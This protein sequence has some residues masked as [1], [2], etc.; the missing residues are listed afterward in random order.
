[1]KKQTCY[2][3]VYAGGFILVRRSELGGVIGRGLLANGSG[4]TVG[5]ADVHE[6]RERLEAASVQPLCYFSADLPK[7]AEDHGWNYDPTDAVTIPR[8]NYAKL[9][10]ALVELERR[11]GELGATFSGRL[12]APAP[13]ATLTEGG[14]S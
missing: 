11:M 12:E 3:G 7:L 5:A 4:A 9:G 8:E 13:R 2:A 10:S 1:M 6:L 14:E